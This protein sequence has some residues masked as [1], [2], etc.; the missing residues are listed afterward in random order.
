MSGGYQQAIQAAIPQALVCF[1]PFRV[2]RVRL[3][4]L[5]VRAGCET[6]SPGCRV[7]PRSGSGQYDLG[8]A[9]KDDKQS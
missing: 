9:G 2:V 4:A 7:I 5:S 1:D 8:A 3:E 6:P